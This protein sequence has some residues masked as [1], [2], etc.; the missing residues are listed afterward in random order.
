LR[1]RAREQMVGA[2]EQTTEEDH[3]MGQQHGSNGYDLDALAGYLAAIDHEDDELDSLRGD[4]MQQCRGP[5]G[6]I[7]DVLLQAKEAGV[8]MPSFRTM[9]A[10]HRADR[11]VAKQV[12][13]LEADDRLSYEQML[14]ALGVFGDTELGKAALDRARPDKG[15]DA[16]SSLS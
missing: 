6:R 11:K 14:D 8:N 13:E 9:L 15:G 16:L 4:Y 2:L 5:R 10:K 3:A 1:D 7:K 12:A